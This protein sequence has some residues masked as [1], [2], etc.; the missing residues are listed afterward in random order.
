MSFFLEYVIQSLTMARSAGLSV[1]SYNI[2]DESLCDV[3]VLFIK[4]HVGD[5][6]SHSA[7]EPPAILDESRDRFTERLGLCDNCSGR[8][9]T[10]SG[11]VP[12][13][14]QNRQTPNNAPVSINDLSRHIINLSILADR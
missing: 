6:R 9:V 11:I 12:T 13:L 14:I 8:T 4:S 3:S 1:I 10:V 2:C 5:S 7:S